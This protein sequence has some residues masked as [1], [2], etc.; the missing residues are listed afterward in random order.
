MDKTDSG[1]KPAALH[2]T[3]TSAR[4][5]TVQELARAGKTTVRNVRAYQDR[6]LLPPPQR[7]GRIGVYDASHL[8]RLRIINQMLARGYT[9]ASIGELLQAWQRGAD[10]A[11][12]LGLET[13]VSSP[14]SDEQPK[15]Y[16]LL[17]LHKLFGEGF[18]LTWL[19]RAV[20]LELLIPEGIGFI[21]PSPR[22]IEVGGALVQAGIPLDEM[23]EVVAQ[24]RGHIQQATD[25]MVR[26][27]EH[28][29]FAPYGKGLPP[30]QEVPRLAEVIWGLRPLVNTAVNAEVA[31]AMEASASRH[32]SDR[33]ATILSYA[34]KSANSSS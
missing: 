28:Y 3:Q 15:R 8:S 1:S 29:L 19:A 25:Q 7:R 23:L 4:E 2:R 34:G 24:L 14:W 17:E 13:A 27:V 33:L 16:S 10:L 26:L 22:M 6:G 30:A 5:Y 31:R 12:L 32:L 11:G 9:L 18:E 20:E 21:A